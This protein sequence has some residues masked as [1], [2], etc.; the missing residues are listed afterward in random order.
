MNS[1]AKARELIQVINGSLGEDTP[2]ANIG[3]I[4]TRHGKN[5]FLSRAKT[6]LYLQ[7]VGALMKEFVPNEDMSQSTVK[8]HLGD[9]IFEA[10]Y[11]SDTSDEVFSARLKDST[12]SLFNSLSRSPARYTWYV[13]IDGLEANGL[14]FSFGDARITILNQYRLGKIFNSTPGL[15]NERRAALL[16]DSVEFLESTNSWGRPV[17]AIDVTARDMEAG[18]QLASRKARQRI[19]ILNFFGALIPNHPGWIFMPGEA[20]RTLSGYVAR[21]VST[22]IPTTGASVAG[23]IG[24]FSLQRLRTAK[25]LHRPLRRTRYL[26]GLTECG[27]LVN[28]ILTS[29]M[30]AGRAAV[31]NRR[32]HAFVLLTTA[33]ETIALPTTDRQELTYRL[34]T[35]VPPM[36]TDSLT[37]RKE[38]SKQIN[39]LYSIR[40]KIVHSGSYEVGD[41][42]LG[43]LQAVV[44]RLII[45]VLL[46]RGIQKLQTTQELDDWFNTRALR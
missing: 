30:W 39:S 10:L 18:K 14:P 23:P 11:I 9:A 31:E 43:M 20:T 26:L 29:I 5:L 13:P 42:D 25:H 15:A 38:L 3:L 46:H 7:T 41:D 21:Q 17:I 37:E 16:R 27:D 22:G 32:E 12:K 45:R 28:T 33:L 4:L 6:E 24:L 44:T 40:S 1:I 35:R 34:K 2:T 8:R 36:L 19:D